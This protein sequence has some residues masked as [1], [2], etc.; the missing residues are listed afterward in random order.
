MKPLPTNT[1]D[2]LFSFIYTAVQSAGEESLGYFR[3]GLSV[4]NKAAA[5][6]FDPVTEADKAVERK[7]RELIEQRFPKHAILGEEFEPRAGAEENDFHWLIDPIDGTRSFI[8]GVPAW[9]VLLALLYKGEPLLGVMHQPYLKETFVGLRN[10]AESQAWFFREKLELD[11][12]LSVSRVE[13]LEQAILFST[14][15]EIFEQIP[16]AF[17]RYQAVAERCKLMR[18]G[19]DCYCYSLLAMGQIDLVIEA[20]LQDYD[21]LPL[22]PI[23]EAAGGVISTWSGEP[24]RAGGQVVAAA[25]P[26]LHEQALRVLNAGQ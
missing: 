2:E 18:Y 8:S 9:G 10:E 24:V 16:G 15:P 11:Q 23:V 14:H 21:I 22:V 13:M 26:A 12:P 3:T 1:I 17:A 25:T 4:D 19:G 20:D 6:K 5:G 7:L